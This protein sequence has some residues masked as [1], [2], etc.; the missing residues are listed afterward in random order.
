MVNTKLAPARHL[1]AVIECPQAI[2]CNPCETACPFG[3]ITVG[4]PITNQPRLDQA[5][6]KG[7]GLCV[8]ACPGLAIFLIDRSYAPG[9]AVVAFPYE[10]LPRP[11]PGQQVAVSDREGKTIGFGQTLRVWQPRRDDPTMVVQ[12]IVPQELAGEVRGLGRES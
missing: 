8:V 3:A 1:V 4:E 12:V 5:R 6:C 9:Q 2:P 11:E 7:C 10:Y